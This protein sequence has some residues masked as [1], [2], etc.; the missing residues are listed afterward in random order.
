MSTSDRKWEALIEQPQAEP[1]RFRFLLAR[2][3]GAD[4]DAAPRRRAGGKPYKIG[5]LLPSTGTGANYMAH[6]I[7]GLPVAIAEL[8]KRGGLL[9]KHQVADGV[10]RRPRP[11]PTSARARRSR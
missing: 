11:S 1:A 9:G 3:G 5:V 6:C 7:K 8:N 4:A 2:R 10:P